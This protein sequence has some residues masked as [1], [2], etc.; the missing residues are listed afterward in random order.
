MSRE[1]ESD[2]FTKDCKSFGQWLELFFENEAVE[3]Q[4]GMEPE[5]WDLKK[6]LYL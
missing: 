2:T 6:V 5:L 3:S 1:A 4:K